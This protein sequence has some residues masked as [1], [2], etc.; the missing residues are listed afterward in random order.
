MAASIAHAGPVGNQYVPQV[1]KA[2]N[3]HHHSSGSSSGTSSSS[4]T[5]ATTTSSSEPAQVQPKQKHKPA[6]PKHHAQAKSTKVAPAAATSVG[7]VDSGGGPWI[8]LAILV[9]V[10]GVSTAVGLTLRRRAA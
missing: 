4:Y 5:P 8:P 9:I 2:G 1:P 3:G 7:S 10:A 6:K